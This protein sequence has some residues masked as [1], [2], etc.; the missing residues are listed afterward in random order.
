MQRFRRIVL[1]T[2][3]AMTGAPEA[4]RAQAGDPMEEQRC[5]W[6][7]LADHGPATSP[8]YN[9][10]VA[11]Q[12]MGQPPAGGQGQNQSQGQA[13]SQPGIAAQGKAG[14]GWKGGRIEGGRTA[15]AGAEMP[16]GAPGIY[17]YC[18]RAGR[19]ALAVAGVRG[20]GSA[21]RL[22]VDGR[23]YG[24]RFSQVGT[25]QY[26][27]PVAPAD[28]VLAALQ[29]GNGVALRDGSGRTALQIPLRG[30]GKAVGAALSFCR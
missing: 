14:A 23:A 15:W 6:R 10:C 20:P 26:A 16:G 18:D 1:A 12:C 17:Y 11:A 29:H 7:C 19:S 4:A 8:A 13:R 28:P 3:L 9:Q 30:S 22:S 5:V 27:A 24:L 2:A 25:S 21:L